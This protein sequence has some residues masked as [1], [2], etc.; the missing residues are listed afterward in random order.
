MVGTDLT[1]PEPVQY[2]QGWQ[3]TRSRACLVRL[4]VM[5]TRPNSLKESTFRSAADGGHGLDQAGAGAIR[6]GLAEDAFEGL[7]GALARD[8]HQAEFIERKHLRRGAVGF[9]SGVE[10]IH[11][12]FAV[13]ALLHVNQVQ[14]DDAAEVA[15][16]DLPDDLLHRFEVG[17]DDGV[18]KARGAFADVLA[19]VDVNGHERF[20]VVD[21]DVAAGFQPHFRAQSLV[22][23]LLDA[24]LLEDGRVLGVELD[25]AHH[26]RLEA[27]DEFDDLA[28][29]LFVVNPDGG[30]VVAEVVAE[31]AFDQIEVAMEQGRRAALLGLGANLVPRA[32]EEFD[33]RADFVVAGIGGGGS[34]DESSGER[35]FGFADEAAQALTVFRGGDLPRDAD[36]I[37]G[38]HVHQEA[39]GQ[40][41]VAGDARAFFAEGFLGDLDDDLLARAE[42]FGDELRTARGGMAVAA[43]AMRRA[44]P[45]GTPAT[46]AN[47][48]LESS[49]GRILNARLRRLEIGFFRRRYW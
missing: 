4:R 10:R 2:G 14:D 28:V 22:Q 3:R 25:A 33:V 20:G 38:G 39:P 45:G 1:M 46:A 44:A 6:A 26:L 15:Q 40:R 36:V 12:F 16:A 37:H 35:A 47:R 48:P 49:T 5:D 23:L 21:D 11:H 42:H 29:L 43:L 18:F 13:A 8:G 34:N 17:L 41:D 24:E 30:V 27:A 19:G 9:E 7:L 31:N 32:A